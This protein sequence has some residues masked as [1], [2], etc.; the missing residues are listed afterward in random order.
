MMAKSIMDSDLFLEMPQSSQNLYFHLL[1]RADDDGFVGNPRQIMRMVNCSE[2]DMRILIMKQFLIPFN[3]GIVVIKHWKIHNYIRNDRY[4]PTIY[5]EEKKLL[6]ENDNKEY[7]L[8]IPDGY[9]R[10]TQYSIGKY[11]IVKD[12]IEKNN[13]NAQRKKELE[14]EFEQLWAMYPKK[15]GKKKA[16]EYYISAR[17]SKDP[18]TF[19]IVKQ[20][21]SNYIFNIKETGLDPKY[22]KH[23]STWFNQQCWKDDYTVYKKQEEKTREEKGYAF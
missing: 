19:E 7:K 3:S 11:S 2:D 16:L 5:Q 4:K 12:S 13:N 14:E 22:I 20:G 1:L 10:E 9:Q 23:G 6:E 8:G 15:Q 17:T 21:I 18:V